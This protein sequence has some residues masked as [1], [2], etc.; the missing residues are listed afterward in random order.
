MSPKLQ[1][2]QC[3][4]A[5]RDQQ[6]MLREHMQEP[7]RDAAICLPPFGISTFIFINS[8]IAHVVTYL[9]DPTLADHEAFSSLS[10][11]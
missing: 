3:P 4:S 9:T 6:W 11:V 10:G 1:V 5:G 8:K 2:A 7:G